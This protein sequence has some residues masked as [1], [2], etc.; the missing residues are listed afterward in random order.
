MEANLG[1]RTEVVIEQDAQG[2]AGSEDMTQEQGNGGGYRED[3]SQK[4]Q[5][6]R[7]DSFWQQLRLGL[8]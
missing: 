3:S 2:K 1:S 5:K 7:T 8:A 6:D 4:K